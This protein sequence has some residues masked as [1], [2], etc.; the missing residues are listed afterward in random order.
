MSDQDQKLTRRDFLK[1]AGAAGAVVGVGGGLTGLAACG[2]TSSSSSSSSSGG[3]ATGRT[4][5]VGFVSPITGPLAAFGEADNYCVQRWKEA[6]KDGIKTADGVLHPVEII[7]RDSQSD[8]NRAATVAGDLITTDQVDCMMVTSTS[9]TVVPVA[10]QAETLG[11]PCMSS[12]SPWQPFYFGRGATPDKPFKWTYHAFWGIETNAGFQLDLWK[13]L[14]N[15]KIIGAM[16]PNDADGL[17]LANRKTGQPAAWIPAG[18]KIIDG[19][20]Y[21][22]GSQDFTPEISKFKAGN[23]QIASGVMIPP[24]FVNYWKQVHQ[25]G[26]HP[27]FCT[28][29]KALLFPSELEAMGAIGEGL[30][31]EVWWHPTFPYKSSLSGETCQQFADA[32][33]AA[34]SKQWTQPLMH[35]IVFEVVADAL[36]RTK[37]V[38]S[39]EEIAA[40]IKATDLDT[41]A[42]HINFTVGGASNP[43]P[44]VATT[45]LAGGQWI[46]GTKYPFDLVIVSNAMAPDAK[47]QAQVY[48]LKWT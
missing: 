12:D 39:K 27:V 37:N 41:L 13:K 38:D 11:V 26:Y 36:K 8:S 48:P 45:P 3:A 35:Y 42:G 25:Q 31:A 17:A 47:I 18:Y 19:G 46:K 9:D 28:M 6:V 4:I 30:T 43:V 24:D 23:A 16:W 14:P 22:D 21:Q 29:S 20:R 1:V 2:G 5:K 15:N 32:W 40:A 34:T 10:D 44:N 33:E 7:V